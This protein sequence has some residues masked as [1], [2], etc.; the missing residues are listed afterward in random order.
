MV[1]L[2]SEEETTS[3]PGEVSHAVTD[4][5]ASTLED[6]SVHQDTMPGED[7]HEVPLRKSTRGKWPPLWMHDYVT[8][9]TS[10]SCHYPMSNYLDYNSMSHG[11]HANLVTF[12]ITVES[13]SFDKACKKSQMARCNER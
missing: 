1:Y 4:E 12:S 9:Q 7:N 5:G 2:C 6:A 13:A 3:E 8:A 11:Y 10:S